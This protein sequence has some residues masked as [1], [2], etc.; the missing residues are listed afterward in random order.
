MRASAISFFL[1]GELNIP[2]YMLKSE[3]TAGT[4]NTWF[5]GMKLAL[6]ANF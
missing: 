1:Q 5:P 3:N 6:G 2:A 4:I